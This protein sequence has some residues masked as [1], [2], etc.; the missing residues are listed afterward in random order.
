MKQRFSHSTNE[1]RLALLEQSI[2][3]INETLQRFEKRFDNVDQELKAIRKESKA[4]FFWLLL[5]IGGTFASSL[6]ILAKGFH[7][8]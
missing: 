3:H 6:G 4:D 1:T 8:F 7:W 5:I 2:G